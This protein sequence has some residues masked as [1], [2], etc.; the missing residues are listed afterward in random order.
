MIAIH[1]GIGGFHPYW[2]TYCDENKIAY[3]IVNCYEDNLSDQLQGCL[4]ILWHYTQSNPKDIVAAK[5]I[6]S[7]AEH[8]G[9][10]VFPKFYSNWHFDD[11]V[12]QK[13]LFE[14]LNIDSVRSYVFYSKNEAMI[15]ANSTIYPK[16]F[17]LKGG[18]GSSNVILVK[19]ADHAKGLIRKSFG[20]GH[21]PFN[22]IEYFKDNYKKWQQRKVP[23]IMVLKSIYRLFTKPEFV[24]VMG[25]EYG[26]AYF[27]DFIP[28]NTFDIKTIV[29]GDKVFAI[30]RNVRKGDFRASGSG[31]IEYDKSIFSNEILNRSFKFAEKLKMDCV[32]FDFVFL[33]GTPKIVEISYGFLPNAYIKCEG[34][35]DKNLNWHKGSFNPY[36]WM[37]DLVL[38]QIR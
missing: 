15:W 1:N 4:A 5:K 38:N 10:I 35:W 27:Q 33:S 31:S 21:S 7:A 14:F 25:K 8:S 36:G 32:A 19:N 17:K 18:A 26:Y 29:I 13:Y 23:L 16:V 20:S 24:K 37:I 11:K 9:L 3:K 22:S 30:K 34:Y 2:R 12:A 6:L 28:N